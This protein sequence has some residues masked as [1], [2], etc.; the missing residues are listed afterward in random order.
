MALLGE[1]DSVFS[2]EALYLSEDSLSAMY[3]AGN[4]KTFLECQIACR[5]LP[6]R[7]S[8][9]EIEEVT[10]TGQEMWL[11]RSGGV[12]T[13]LNTAYILNASGA[14]GQTGLQDQRE[15]FCVTKERPKVEYSYCNVDSHADNI[16]SYD[17]PNNVAD[18]QNCCD[19]K[20]QDGWYPLGGLSKGS[21]DDGCQAFWRW[22]E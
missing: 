10:V 21:A 5:N 20:V 8:M 6:G 19:S 1:F 9:P 4:N 17:N 2:E 12:P 22:A 3:D 7:W 13:E 14:A 15:C 11:R 16:D 18:F